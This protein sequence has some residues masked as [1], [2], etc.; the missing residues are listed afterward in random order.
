MKPPLFQPARCP[1]ALA[2]G[3]AA[4][5]FVQAL[6]CQQPDHS[7]V[8]AHTLAEAGKLTESE[9]ILRED[10][11][12]N[13]A[14]AGAHFLLGYVLFREQKPKESLAEFTAGARTQRPAA[15]DFRVVASDYVL[16]ADY[17]D[18][19]KWFS[20]V[21][22]EKPDDPTAWYLL[23]RAQYNEDHFTAAIA[24]FEHALTLRPLYIEAENNMGLAWE[25]LNNAARALS[26]YRTAVEWQQHHPVDA[27]PY[28][29]LGSLL[30]DQNQA[31]KALPY[32]QVAVGLAPK[33]PRVHEELG[34]A[35][36]VRNQLPQAQHELEQAASLAP[37]ASGLHFKLGQ[38]YRRQGL[39]DKAQQEFAI[40]A[41]LNSTHSS[42]DTPNPY[43]PN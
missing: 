37:S 13:P 32:L 22:A 34:R 14:S 38:I 19:E 33:N 36:D 26:A 28:L 5:F 23:G 4:V 25:G 29:N 39:R 2:V 17:A 31:D 12:R 24:S 9:A 42:M 1:P 40:C 11:R 8:Q 18:A 27:Q 43:T 21:C 16:L 3:L 20:E 6:F 15:D 10:L 35:Y 41:K 30:T 7:L